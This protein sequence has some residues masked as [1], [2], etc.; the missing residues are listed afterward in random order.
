[1]R[2]NAL[3]RSMSL[4]PRQNHTTPSAAPTRWPDAMQRIG[5]SPA[6]MQAVAS[7]DTPAHS[8]VRRE[9]P[10]LPLLVEEG[11]DAQCADGVVSGDE[12]HTTPAHRVT[13]ARCRAGRD[14]HPAAGSI[15]PFRSSG[16]AW[17]EVTNRIKAVAASGSFET[18]MT[19][20]ENTMYSCSPPG[21]SPT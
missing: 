20:M 21:R 9:C 18:A 17:G 6:R 7:F 5:R 19:A 11:R 15:N 1:M 13:L 12:N 3:V 4:A 16:S 8:H 2:R 10:K 14:L